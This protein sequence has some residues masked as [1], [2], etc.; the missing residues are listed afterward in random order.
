MN[1]YSLRNQI[2]SLARLPISPPRLWKVDY[3]P[4]IPV[5]ANARSFDLY[6]KVMDL[7]KCPVTSE[8]NFHPGIS[9]ERRRRILSPDGTY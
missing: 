2:L 8:T 5:D 3:A 9:Y 4:S 6:T 7:R 1:P